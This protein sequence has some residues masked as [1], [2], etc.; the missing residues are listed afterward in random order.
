MFYIFIY[1]YILNLVKHALN[2]IFIHKILLQN[3][4][5]IPSMVVY[6][7]VPSVKKAEAG[8]L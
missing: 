3:V 7:S 5:S 2:F 6:S 4:I 1:K 8:G